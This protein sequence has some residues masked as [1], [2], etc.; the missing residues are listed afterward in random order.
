MWNAA[1]A[2]VRR[3][4][5]GQRADAGVVHVALAPVAAVA[6]PAGLVVERQHL[7]ALGL[8]P[9]QVLHLLELA[10]ARSAARSCDLGEVLGDVVQLPHVVVERAG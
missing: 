9:P 1:V 10:R 4:R 2:Q 8:L 7:V 6:E 5:L 3:E